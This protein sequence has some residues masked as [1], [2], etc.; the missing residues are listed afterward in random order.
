MLALGTVLSM[1]YIV[2]LAFGGKVTAFSMLPIIVI[3]YRYKTAWGLFAG[4][5][6]SLL[7]MLLGLKNL[8]YAT[9]GAAVAAIILLDYVVAFTFLGFAGI[10]RGKIK[11]SGVALALGSVMV[12]A[13]RYICHVIS[14]CT[15]WAGVSIPSADGLIYSLAY[16]AAYMIPETLT[17]A[18]GAYFI[19]K[20][21]V[22]TEENIRRVKLENSASTNLY[23]A[24]PPVMSV[25]IAFVLIFGMIQTEE[26]FDITAITRADAFSWISVAVI[27]AIGAAVSL[28]IRALRNHRVSR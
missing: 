1:V 16:N 6:Y 21:F 3:A 22:I 27:I 13:L 26:G 28:A 23:A 9:S 18:V 4:F 14:G 24:I 15:V 20:A 17:T 7:Q 8:S 11:D 10:F 5:A 12:C 2:E 19:G 25:V